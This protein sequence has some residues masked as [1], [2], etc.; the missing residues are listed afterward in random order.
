MS[1]PRFETLIE[2]HHDAIHRYIWRALWS[3]GNSHPGDDAE[4]L[5]QEAFLK[6]FDAYPS[7]RSASNLRAWLYKIAT[8]CLRT[9]WRQSAPA[10]LELEP[11]LVSPADADIRAVE[12]QSGSERARALRRG[13]SRLPE[14]QRQAVILRYLDELEYDAIALILDCSNDSARAN[15]SHGLRQLRRFMPSASDLSKEEPR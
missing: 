13:L 15:V 2:E 12:S 10:P 3:G 8:N 9:H 1:F 14:K 7:L 4:D 6:A 5:T 11:E